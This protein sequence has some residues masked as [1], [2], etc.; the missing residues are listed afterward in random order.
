MRLRGL[1]EQRRRACKPSAALTVRTPAGLCRKEHALFHSRNR[2]P[3][4][5]QRRL[6]LR[7]EERPA[8]GRAGA[9]ITGRSPFR[10]ASEARPPPFGPGRSLPTPDGL[11]GSFC[12]VS[13]SSRGRPSSCRFFVLP[14][15]LPLLGRGCSGGRYWPVGEGD[16]DTSARVSPRGSFCF[17]T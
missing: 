3:Q 16:C 2:I 15:R 13:Q 6:R 7:G 5:R 12:H 14:R 9:G 11:A 8:P 17:G 1:A 10:A 4:R